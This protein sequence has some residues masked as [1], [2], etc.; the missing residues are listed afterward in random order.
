[1]KAGVKAGVKLSVKGAANEVYKLPP[2]LF[3]AR[4]K[5]C[6]FVLGVVVLVVLSFWSLDLQW[7]KFLSIAAFSK[8]GRFLA[9]LTQLEGNPRFIQKLLM[10]ALETLAMSAVGTLLAVVLGMA[11][12]WVADRISAGLRKWLA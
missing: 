1:M 11:L 3:D 9:E 5:A 8:M 2:R 7:A 12:V 6:W 4:C 10:A